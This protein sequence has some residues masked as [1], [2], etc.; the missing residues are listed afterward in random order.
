MP[1]VSVWSKVTVPSTK[2]TYRS[3]MAKSC[4]RDAVAPGTSSLWNSSPFSEE[5]W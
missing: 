1:D 4:L 2:T 5:T 3:V